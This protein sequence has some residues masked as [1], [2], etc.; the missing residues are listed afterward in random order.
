M[1]AEASRDRRAV[2]GLSARAR[3]LLPLFLVLLA[4]LTVLRLGSEAPTGDLHDFH[5]ASMGTTWSVRLVDPELTPRARLEIEKAI[6]ERLANVDGLMS[7]W[8]ADSE[9]SRF[10]RFTS[11]DPFPV[12]AQ[13]LEV[14]RVAR[15]VSELTA[16]AF[17]VTVGPL[18]AAWG[19]GATER[20]PASPSAKE[21]AALRARVGWRRVRVDASSQSLS[22][23]HPETVCDL[24][25]VA[26]GYGVDEVARALHELGHTDFLVEV[27]GEL[28]AQGRRGPD[29]PWRV[30]IERPST[31]ERAVFA[32]LELEDMSLATSGDYRNY[33]E[34]N[35][36]RLSHLIDPRTARPVAH[37]LASVSVA[38][39][40]AAHADA[41]ATG[42]GVLG[43]EEGY[44]LAVRQGLAAYF[45][46]READGALRGL[47]TPGFPPV[48]R[49]SADSQETGG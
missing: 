42:L 13:T 32:V 14:F 12:S 47:A 15:E 24:S 1:A 31:A 30:A 22:K 40:D 48:E 6:E 29:R 49:R 39:A 20:A 9:L 11:T 10:N 38:H 34:E 23:T 19:F 4:V 3:W 25:A 46:V 35:G 5:G 7:T 37:A 36:V 8:D 28:R 43:P 41:L 26:K 33:F 27:G 45:I 18:V 2:L 21:L 44:P 16:G 17:D